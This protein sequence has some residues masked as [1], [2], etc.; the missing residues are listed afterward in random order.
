MSVQSSDNVANSICAADQLWLD[1]FSGLR[2]PERSNEA[3][4]APKNTHQVAGA[5][6][7]IA[8]GPSH[9]RDLSYEITLNG[10]KASPD[11]SEQFLLGDDLARALNQNDQEVE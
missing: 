10:G 5:R 8:Q 11:T 3:I 6:L 1:G 2:S 4:S 7:A 9:K